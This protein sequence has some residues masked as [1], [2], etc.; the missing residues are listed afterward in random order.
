MSAALVCNS[1][2]A[3]SCQFHWKF[4]SRWKINLCSVTITVRKFQTI[5]TFDS[6]IHC[7]SGKTL[8]SS[9]PVA[10]CSY[11]SRLGN[12]QCLCPPVLIRPVRP[13]WV[14]WI[15]AFHFLNFWSLDE[16][17]FFHFWR[18]LANPTL[19]TDWQWNQKL[20]CTEHDEDLL[21][22]SLHLTV[23]GHCWR[24]FVR[25]L[26]ILVSAVQ[27]WVLIMSRHC[28][29]LVACS[30]Q[31]TL[32]VQSTKYLLVCLRSLKTMLWSCQDIGPRCSARVRSGQALLY[33]ENRLYYDVCHAVSRPWFSPSLRSSSSQNAEQYQEANIS[34]RKSMLFWWFWEIPA[35]GTFLAS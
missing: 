12:A 33:V 26:P 23:L 17:W 34:T 20:A 11:C 8:S 14:S 1:F 27:N 21:P 35:K 4:H 13:S 9:K 24:I 5:K 22:L 2:L 30:A 15:F 28:N 31:R 16:L 19:S 25:H 18:N 7:K 29:A 32:P 10:A 6:R 3:I